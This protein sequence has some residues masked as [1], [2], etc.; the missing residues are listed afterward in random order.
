MALSSK[1]ASNCLVVANHASI[2]K[3][4]KVNM[5]TTPT[6]C[7]A[8]GNFKKPWTCKT[9]ELNFQ[10]SMYSKTPVKTDGSPATL[11][12]HGTALKSSV[13]SVIFTLPVFIIITT[14][15]CCLGRWYLLCQ[16]TRQAA[17]GGPGQARYWGFGCR[18]GIEPVAF[19]GTSQF[20]RCSSNC[21]TSLD[22]NLRVWQICSFI[23]LTPGG[24]VCPQTTTVFSRAYWGQA[25]LRSLRLT[26]PHSKLM[27]GTPDKCS[28]DYHKPL[29]RSKLQAM[30]WGQTKLRLKVKVA[31]NLL[32]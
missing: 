12:H 4:S 23:C 19:Q 32:N 10:T 15:L 1:A 16:S 21:I 29:R 18:R 14:F 27:E 31:K 22:R 13:L 3:T 26:V 17:V 30:V 24:S 20:L 8:V 5:D 11:K 6:N 28:P 2:L 25:Q 9:N 7:W